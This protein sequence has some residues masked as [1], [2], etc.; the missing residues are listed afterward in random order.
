LMFDFSYSASNVV[1]DPS[2]FTIQNPVC[3]GQSPQYAVAATLFPREVG[4][5]L[6]SQRSLLSSK[7]DL[8]IR[9]E[10][11]RVMSTLDDNPRNQS[12]VTVLRVTPGPKVNKYEQ[13]TYSETIPEEF[14]D[15]ETPST[16][17]GHP[18]T[19][20]ERAGG[21]PLP[22][23]SDETQDFQLGP[24]GPAQSV[25]SSL[26][27]TNAPKQL[28]GSPGSQAQLSRMAAAATSLFASSKRA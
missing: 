1:P 22:S 25:V 2:D 20:L 4:I 16:A 3:S 9:S 15:D 14:K 8:D 12:F 28:S 11:L 18:P 24:P 7:K 27:V 19:T 10:I 5:V 6:Q 23:A 17:S 26:L 21:H 13:A